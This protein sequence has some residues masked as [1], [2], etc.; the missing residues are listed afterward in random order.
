M[1]PCILNNKELLLIV[2]MFKNIFGHVRGDILKE[3]F[4]LK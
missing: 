1:Y 3:K 2:E 4:T